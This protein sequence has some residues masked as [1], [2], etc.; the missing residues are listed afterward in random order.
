MQPFPEIHDALDTRDVLR[1]VVRAL[2]ERIALARQRMRC[3]VS[4]ECS[5]D[6]AASI[7][8]MGDRENRRDPIIEIDIVA[9]RDLV[10]LL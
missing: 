1:Q 5:I 10:Q 3:V 2:F 4:I 8:S 9:A 6:L 7:V